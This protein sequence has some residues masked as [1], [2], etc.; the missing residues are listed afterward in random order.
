M[1][2]KNSGLEVSPLQLFFD[3]DDL[4]NSYLQNYCHFINEEEDDDGNDDDC[5]YAAADENDDDDDD[6]DET[7]QETH[8]SCPSA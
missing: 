8:F 1:K 6:G 7:V 2:G 5:P 3:G 4:T